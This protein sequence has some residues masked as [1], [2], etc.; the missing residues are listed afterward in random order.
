MN[1]ET[2]MIDQTQT[3]MKIIDYQPSPDLRGELNEVN[4]V[5]FH[6]AFKIKIIYG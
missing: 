3:R 2:H 5:R 6:P 4:H 1:D